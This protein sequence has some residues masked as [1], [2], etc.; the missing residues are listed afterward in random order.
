MYIWNAHAL[1]KEL[2]ERTITEKQKSTYLIFILIL[3]SIAE[4]L[5]KSPANN[6]EIALRIGSFIADIFIIILGVYY[7]FKCNEKGDNKHFL[8]RYI[9]LSVP[10]AVQVGLVVALVNI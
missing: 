6:L 9:C 8:E 1:A 7:C 2:Q 4:F 5:C 10:I 3:M